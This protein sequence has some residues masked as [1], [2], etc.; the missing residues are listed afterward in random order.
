MRKFTGDRAMTLG[1]VV[2]SFA[3]ALWQRPG[4]AMTDTKI[5]LHVDPID[6]LERVASLWTTTGDLGQVHSSQY[7]GYLWPMGPFFAALHA[8]DVSPWVAQRLWLGVIFAVSALGTLKLMDIVAGRPR[9]VAHVVAA[10]VYVVNPYTAV[11]AARATVI[12]LGYAALPWLLVVVARGVRAMRESRGWRDWRAWLAPAAFALILTSIGGGVNGAVVGWMLVGPLVLMIYE[13]LVGNVRWR[14]SAVFGLRVGVLGLLASLWWVLPLLAHVRYGVDY[15]QFTEQPS[16]IWATNST[17]EALRL[18]AYWT[19]YFGVGFY[20]AQRPIF[21]ESATLLFNPF[22]VGASL[23]VPALALAGLVWSRRF[24]Y[25]PFLLLV[26][27]VG[28]AIEVAGF[29]SGTPIRQGMEWVYN[30]I[31]VLRFMRTTQKAAPLVAIGIAGLLG[32]GAQLAW[33][34]LRALRGRRARWLAPLAASLALAVLIALAALPLTRGSA[35]DNQITWDRIPE[36]WVQAGRDLDRELP[37]NAR[38][39]VLPGQIFAYYR[40]G[41]TVDS[42][43]PR[44][45]DKPV[46]VRYETPYSDAHASD[47]LTTVDGLVQQKR[48][49]P[50]QLQ[51]LLGLMGVRAVI[52]GSDDDI[53]RTGALAASD[54]AAELDGQGLSR[55]ARE[56][57]PARRVAP[58]KKELGPG[59]ALPQVRRYDLPAG[60]GLVDVEPLGP[61]T[62]VDGSAPGLAGLAAF[63][64]LPDDTPIFYA[65]DLTPA[66]IR[67]QAAAGR[68]RG[69][70]R[71]EPPARLHPHQHPAERGPDAGHRRALQRGRGADQ[72]LP[73]A[74][75]ERRDRGGAGG[76]SLHSRARGGRPAGLPREGRRGRLR[77]RRVDHVDRPL[78]APAPAL[79]RDRLRAAARRSLRRPPAH[80]RLAR[81]GEGG[82]GERRARGPRPR[83]HPRRARPD[84]RGDGARA[85]HARRPVR[86]GAQGLGRLSRDPHPRRSGAAAAAPAGARRRRRWPGRT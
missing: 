29:P 66:Q 11:F 68:R 53:S 69:G 63:G 79:D 17:T 35:P 24:R 55:P 45:T 44:L 76:R 30:E 60:R 74:R 26:L 21:S 7:S 84:R 18:M 80:P 64:A 83:L 51:P 19:S 22:L 86:G 81:G 33:V 2:L 43:L 25:A 13:P 50:G 27:L 82:R 28:L 85:A 78:P 1:F 14:D 40:W 71:L 67:R 16:S 8:I 48:L 36:P 32:L 38:A 47:L 61:A 34:R 62:I 9:G 75:P 56:Y 23:L 77:R 39:M 31:F 15:L 59:R 49:L 5:D 37:P 52:T 70:D 65:G 73:R 3:L 57:G 54:A 72:P 20:G 58:A 6:F 46:V 12:L 4:Q 41:G 10:A 42:I